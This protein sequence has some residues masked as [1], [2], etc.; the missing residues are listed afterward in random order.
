MNGSSDVE[1]GCLESSIIAPNAAPITS[2]SEIELKKKNLYRKGITPDTKTG[3]QH[4]LVLR[5][6]LLSLSILLGLLAFL[7][8]V[9]VGFAHYFFFTFTNQTF[10]SAERVHL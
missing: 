5:L 7:F 2:P 9:F 10:L 3:R 4:S 6:Y 8:V 1:F